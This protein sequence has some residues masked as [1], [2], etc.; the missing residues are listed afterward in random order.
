MG[1]S[2]IRVFAEIGG[3]NP[4]YHN[5]CQVSVRSGFFSLLVIVVLASGAAAQAPIKKAK[6]SKIGK[7]APAAQHRVAIQVNQNDK[8]VMDLA[9]NNVLNIMEYYVRPSP[10]KSL[11]EGRDC[12]CCA[13]TPVP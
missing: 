2:N 5:P 11:P 10:L 9:L 6:Q 13:P 1:D 8:G 7:L 4:L 12:T 3:S